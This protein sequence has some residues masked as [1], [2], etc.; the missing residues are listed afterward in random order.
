MFWIL[1]KSLLQGNLCFWESP[2][3]E[4]SNSLADESSR[5]RSGRGLSQ[6]FVDIICLLI[7]LTTL[8]SIVTC[9]PSSYLYCISQNHG[10][11]VHTKVRHE[12]IVQ[13][14]LKTEG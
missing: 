8:E 1:F 14:C 11:E 9:Q 5:R 10:M 6:F 4:F 7:F 12:Q 2:E 13:H 3:M